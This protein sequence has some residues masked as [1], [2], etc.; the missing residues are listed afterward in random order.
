MSPEKIALHGKLEGLRFFRLL[1]EIHDHGLSGILHLKRGNVVKEIYFKDGNPINARSN[2]T[3]ETLGRVLLERGYISQEDYNQSLA[4]MEKTGKKHGQ[5]LMEMGV[6]P[7]SLKKA[8]EMQAEERILDVFTWEEGSYRFIEKNDIDKLVEAL[9]LNATKIIYEGTVK[10]A[11]ISILENIMRSYHDKKLVFDS[12]SP[13]ISSARMKE[14]HVEFLERFDGEKTV[15]EVIRESRININLAVRIILAGLLLDVL[16]IKREEVEEK[17][18]EEAPPPAEVTVEEEMS[19]KDRKM[20]EA[21]ERNLEEIKKKNYFELFNLSPDNFSESELKKSYF[22]LARSFHPDRFYTFHPRVK[23]LA[24]EIFTLINEAFHT[25]LNPSERAS[26]QTAL[27]T[28]G[29]GISQKDAQTAV[30]AELEFQ[31]GEILLKQGKVEEAKEYFER[32]HELNPDEPEYTAYLGWVLFRIGKRKGD[33]A[34]AKKGRSMLES[35]VA[36]S[37]GSEKA[38]FFLGQVLK[39]ENELKGAI[40]HF[41]KVVQINPDNLDAVRELR[42]LRM[43]LEKEDTRKEKGGIFKKIFKK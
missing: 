13:I 16:H 42:I 31:K 28:T 29:K 35:V 6:L 3:R 9:P 38:H 33:E 2:L 19:E 25:L 32:A 7:I 37:E 27:S 8:L 4:I 20:L 36:K 12:S 41:E 34:L 17:G 10:K 24:E 5:I 15:D 18:A 43:R 26:Y 1:K 40:R 22:K 21:L 14:S 11:P 23:A 39:V 30:S